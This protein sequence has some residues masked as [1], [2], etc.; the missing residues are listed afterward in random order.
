MMS[1]A[2]K[3][4][5]VSRDG[6]SAK[7]DSLLRDLIV[8][9]VKIFCAVGKD[10][11]KWEEAMDWLCVQMDV[12]GEMPGVLVN[13]TSHPDETVAEVVEFVENWHISGNNEIRVIEI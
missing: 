10:C 1:K 6:Y 5:L 11:E 7:H 8:Q 13:T 12:D 3:V 4:V 9:G 2:Q